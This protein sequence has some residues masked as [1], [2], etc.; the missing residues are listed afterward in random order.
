MSDDRITSKKTKDVQDWQSGMDKAL[1]A[2]LQHLEEQNE[3]QKDTIKQLRQENSK[4]KSDEYKKTITKQELK[5]SGYGG[6]WSEAQLEYILNHPF[7][8]ARMRKGQIIKWS[9]EDIIQGIVLLQK[10]SLQGNKIKKC[11]FTRIYWKEF[12]NL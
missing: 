2:R 11:E 6:P 9:G 1:I 12:S 3:K 5:K 7:R 4:L 8:T 10:L